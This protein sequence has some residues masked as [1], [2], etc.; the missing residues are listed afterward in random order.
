MSVE[1]IAPEL[2]PRPE[3]DAMVSLAIVLLEKSELELLRGL[4]EGRHRPAVVEAFRR[5]TKRYSSRSYWK[6]RRRLADL[7]EKVGLT[8]E[9]WAGGRNVT[10]WKVHLVMLLVALLATT[11]VV[12]LVAAA[13]VRGGFGRLN[14]SSA[15]TATAL[16]MISPTVSP[17]TVVTSMPTHSATPTSTATSTL[18]PT[19]TATATSTLSPTPTLASV[20][21]C[22]P[23]F[24]DPRPHARDNI[25]E[26]TEY[27]N[28]NLIQARPEQFPIEGIFIVEGCADANI[29]LSQ[30]NFDLEPRDPNDI[31]ND[32][33]EPEFEQEA[34]YTYTFKI[35]FINRPDLKV[36]AYNGESRWTWIDPEG[37]EIQ[38]ILAFKY[39][40]RINRAPT[41]TPTP[42]AVI[43]PSNAPETGD[44]ENTTAP[45]P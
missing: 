9:E 5:L 27:G 40:I 13:Y 37:K 14:E 20:L 21:G 33:G 4:A 38:G 8:P 32:Y 42:T 18:T 7:A 12:L 1:Q 28:Q 41:D 34:P 30:Y 11:G 3:L 39:H 43:V 17:S 23:I 44:D 16:A 35:T 22:K 19:F 24:R 10:G 6:D 31:F 25:I 45:T 2:A 15:R 26:G 36:G 29:D